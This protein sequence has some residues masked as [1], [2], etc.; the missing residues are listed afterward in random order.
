[1]GKNKVSDWDWRFWGEDNKSRR[2]KSVA[3]SW[4]QETQNRVFPCGVLWVKFF[5]VRVGWMSS[6][7][8]VEHFHGRVCIYRYIRIQRTKGLLILEIETH[9]KRKYEITLCVS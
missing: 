9:D 7:R 3:R 5:K 1:M 4:G 6:G 8:L 2:G